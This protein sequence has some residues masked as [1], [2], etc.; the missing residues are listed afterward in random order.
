MSNPQTLIVPDAIVWSWTNSSLEAMS[1]LFCTLELDKL[2]T[3]WNIFGEKILHI[4]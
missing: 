4:Y 1:S 2:D 3:H